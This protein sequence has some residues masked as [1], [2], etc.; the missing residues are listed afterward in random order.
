MKK[1]KLIALDIIEGLDDNFYIVDI[2]GLIGIQSILQFKEEFV[3]NILET[4]GE[5][6]NIECSEFITDH[7]K[8]ITH[9]NSNVTIMNSGF[10]HEN[11]LAWR[12]AYDLPCPQINGNIVPHS[13]PDYPKYIL[14]P[15]FSFRGRGII[16]SNNK[17][18][19]NGKGFIEEFIPSKLINEHCYSIRVIMVLNKSESIPLLFLNRICKNPIIK[20]LHGGELTEDE[21]LSYIS[22]LKSNKVKYVKNED[23]K[24]KEF[25]KKLNFYDV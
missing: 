25:I 2:N 13:N 11:K 24:L 23:I 1:Y 5:L 6:V 16:L 19:G 4:F 9:T 8:I 20:D 3:G 15:E 12:K 22:N 17:F 7:S 14:K 18:V 21:N 10:S